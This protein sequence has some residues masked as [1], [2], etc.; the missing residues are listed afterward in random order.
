MLPVTLLRIDTNTV[1]AIYSQHLVIAAVSTRKVS[2][3]GKQMTITAE[4]K[5]PSGGE[6][7]ITVDV[8]DRAK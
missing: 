6:S 2:P 5:D 8:F 1:R 4:V 3:D 7:T